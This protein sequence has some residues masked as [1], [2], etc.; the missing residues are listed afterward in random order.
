MTRPLDV[1]V[2]DDDVASRSGIAKA[3]R[4]LGHSCREAP[5]GDVAWEM[6]QERR[7]DVVIS[8]WQMPG[9]SGPQL[10]QRTR[11]ANEDAPYTYFILVTGFH[12]RAHLLEGMAAGADDFQKKPIDLDELEAR[13]V[14]AARVVALHRRLTERT[15]H[16]RRDS[17]TFFAAS[18]TDALTGVGNRLR[19]NEELAAA[20]SRAE[21]Y[22]HRYA[23]AICDVDRFKEFNDTF[24]HL[25]GD[26]ALRRVA[27]A[28][29]AE[30]RVGDSVYR[31]GGEE[32]V[33]LLPEQSLAE[34]ARALERIR[35]AIEKLAI[36][37]P[38]GVLTVSSGVAAFDAGV[39]ETVEAWLARADTAL[40][41]AKANGRNRVESAG[42]CNL[43]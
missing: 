22:G 37:A 39:D 9:M 4:A 11:V 30:L 36:E 3:V 41:N 21:R 17:Q 40:Y 5:D 8:D 19:M 24:G 43:H 16:L 34:G 25:A 38:R 1:L 14:S 33:V 20:R 42:A 35:A 31:Y 26:E 18:R 12:D 23:V 29:R 32:L 15:D 10:C 6:L 28:V 27:D 2:V 7:A 13:L